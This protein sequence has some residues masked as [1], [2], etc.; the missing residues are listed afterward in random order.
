MALAV[1][2]AV[3]TAYK[4]LLSPLARI[5]YVLGRQGKGLGETEGVEDMGLIVEVLETREAVERGEGLGRLRAE[6]QGKSSV[7]A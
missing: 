2:N 6:N 5:E 1:S 7:L 3:N 4:T